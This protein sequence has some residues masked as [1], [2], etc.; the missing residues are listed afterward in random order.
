VDGS[1]TSFE[2]SAESYDAVVLLALA[3]TANGADDAAGVARSI[4]DVSRRG[5]RCTTFAA[6][7]ALL[8]GHKDINYDGVSGTIDLDDDGDPTS[9]SFGIR[10]FTSDSKLLTLEYRTA[11]P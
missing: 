1:L 9:A 2:S 3:T 5:T 8:R 11:G 10:Q 7:A 6:C 4:V